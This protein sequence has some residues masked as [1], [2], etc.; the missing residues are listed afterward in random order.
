MAELK[1]IQDAARLAAPQVLLGLMVVLSV[2]SLPVPHAGEVR[3]SLVL[4]TVYYWAIYRP[5]LVPP[6]LCFTVG[7]LLDILSGMP[8]GL[9]ALTLVAVQWI[10]RDQRR[11]LMGQPYMA[12][13][14]VFG[15]VAMLTA[16][17][18]WGLYGLLHQAWTPLLPLAA[19]VVFSLLLF[20]LVTLLLIFVHRLLP[21]A[22]R[23]FP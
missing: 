23:A 3:P 10:V 9:N 8:L 19:S 12:I 15:L 2:L 22:S 17:L 16:G 6:A 11:F 4:M 7:L 13:W 5:T 21:V 14:A 1:N 18:Q 20:P